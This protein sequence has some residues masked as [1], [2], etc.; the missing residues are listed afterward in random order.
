MNKNYDRTKKAL[1]AIMAPG[2]RRKSKPQSNKY[3]RIS[4]SP[5]IKY[6]DTA[7]NTGITQT[8]TV[9]SLNL[10]AQGSDNNQ[11]IGRKITVKNI[12]I[13]GQV[14]ATTADL[15]TAAAYPESSDT[16]RVAIVYD[17]QTNG[18]V[19]TYSQIFNA[20]AGLYA[21]FSPRNL[22]YIDR[23]VVLASESLNISVSGPNG[24]N[25]ERFIKCSLETRYDNTTA[26][27]ASVE[28]G[29]FFL[30]YADIN[31]SGAN[32]ATLTCWIRVQFTDM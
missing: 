31:G 9:D 23:F 12:Q 25:F 15:G 10:T 3:Q 4:K 28:S 5:E 18:A 17:K 21:P 20:G 27:I 13:K 19:P 26:V 32:N 1:Q 24:V 29:G 14:A 16:I 22:D 2:F 8:G 11:R 6:V 30:V 7:T